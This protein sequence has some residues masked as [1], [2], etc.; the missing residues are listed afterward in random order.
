MS[1]NANAPSSH[2]AEK[3]LQFPPEPTKYA[4]LK[5]Q[6]FVPVET[7]VECALKYDREIFILLA[8]FHYYPLTN[9]K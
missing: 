8:V 6:K 9:C 2:P 3:R 4:T 7:K 5:G 1:E